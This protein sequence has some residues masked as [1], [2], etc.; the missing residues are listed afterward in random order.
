MVRPDYRLYAC[1]RCRRL[2]A[3]CSVCDR[4]QWYCGRVCS[5]R[6]RRENSARRVRSALPGEPAGSAPARES[7]GALPPA[8]GRGAGCRSESDASGYPRVVAELHTARHDEGGG[9]ASAVSGARGGGGAARM[10][11][12]AMAF[13]VLP[14]RPT[15]DGDFCAGDV[16]P[17]QTR[18]G[19]EDDCCRP[20]SASVAAVPRREVAR[21]HHCAPARNASRHGAARSGA[22]RHRGG[23]PA[24]L[25]VEDRPLCA[26]HPG[27]AR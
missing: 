19:G 6:S 27:N 2:V 20:G 9:T 8:P 21:P 25:A 4:G 18:Q 16:A 14:A 7:A 22:S 5:Q 24:A 15:P 1:A 11:C 17:A 26:V 3:I 23:E 12:S 10:S 13:A